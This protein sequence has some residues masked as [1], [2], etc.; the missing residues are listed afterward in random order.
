[1]AVAV[2]GLTG[3][4]IGIFGGG[5][6]ACTFNRA[7]RL[8]DDGNGIGFADTRLLGKVVEIVNNLVGVSA[9]EMLL[10]VGL[11]EQ[12]RE[13]GGAEDDRIAKF[14]WRT[15]NV[16]VGVR[17]AAAEGGGWIGGGI[18]KRPLFGAGEGANVALMREVELGWR[19]LGDVNFVGAEYR[20]TYA[21]EGALGGRGVAIVFK[22]GEIGPRQ[23]MAQAGGSRRRGVSI[24]LA[25]N[26]LL[27][28]LAGIHA[29][30]EV[31]T[32]LGQD[33]EA[34]LAGNSTTSRD[35]AGT[36]A[37]GP[38]DTADYLELGG[39]EA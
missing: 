13:V 6:A 16:G 35:A 31:S 33:I 11:I 14:E 12:R 28:N 8:G 24:E 7:V 34:A 39:G 25:G 10:R 2:G 17:R 1:M 4:R 18:G 36:I 38:A 20:T 15:R 22:Q 19:Q 32:R 26:G 27:H 29:Q 37:T 5:S 30:G 3:W 21:D 23:R 9:A